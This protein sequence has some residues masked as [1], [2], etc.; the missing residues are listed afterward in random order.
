MPRKVFISVLGTGFYGAC[1]YKRGKF[2]SSTT[3]FIQQATLEY[4]NVG[5]EWTS[6]DRVLILLTDG[7]RK[8]NWSKAIRT[9]KS[10]R[11]SEEENYLGLE[12]VLENMHLLCPVET[13]SI[14]D[15][16]DEAEMWQIFNALYD[17]LETGD[18]LYFDLT[19]SF[20]YLPMLVLVLGNYAKFL[21][22]VTVK[23]I[24]Y[25]NYEARNL[26]SNVAPLMDILPLTILQD[27]TFAAADL[28]R[29]GNI[30]RLKSLKDANALVP[31]IRSKGGNNISRREAEQPLTSYIDALES[32]LGDMKLCLVP[33]ILKG[34][35][36]NDIKN[37]HE[38]VINVL[39][40]VIAPIPPIIN[41]IQDSL[42][43]FETTDR[44]HPESLFNGYVAAKWCYDHQLYQQAI[45]IIEE[46]ITTHFC[47]YLGVDEHIYDQRKAANAFLRHKA[48]RDDDW[49][50][51]SLMEVRSIAKQA[52][53]K[54]NVGAFVYKMSDAARWIHDKRNTYNHASMGRD[55][56][57]TKEDILTLGKKINSIINLIK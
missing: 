41:K 11:T 45:T 57:L 22:D 40:N 29:N 44:N 26:E 7:A 55:D 32:L 38:A 25:G 56:L 17:A 34:D 36:V 51:E 43:A 19:H 16:K 24:S 49:K 39:E 42:E 46:N 33:N 50:D 47:Q 54:M 12:Q 9:R 5:G 18:E 53:T 48:F 4:L 37:Y 1:Q 8:I 23:H 13:I 31:L 2:E 20:R 52:S 6:A 3:R 14:L 28:I 30:E 15:G 10:P 21:K 27:W 35:V